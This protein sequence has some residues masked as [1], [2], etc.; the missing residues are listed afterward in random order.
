MKSL[1]LQEEIENMLER[2][3]KLTL[4]NQIIYDTVV[5]IN[6][7]SQNSPIESYTKLY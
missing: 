1:Y 4:K 5:Y 3:G 7:I 6:G 2:D